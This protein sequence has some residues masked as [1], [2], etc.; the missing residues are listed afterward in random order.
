MRYTVHPAMSRRHGGHS[1]PLTL[2]DLLS[3]LSFA[4]RVDVTRFYTIFWEIT[5]FCVLLFL[6]KQAR[7]NQVEQFL[8]S[9]FY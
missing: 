7:V 3:H 4:H 5:F 6:I 8:L 9:T 1:H 2:L